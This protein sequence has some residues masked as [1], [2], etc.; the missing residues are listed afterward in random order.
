MADLNSP[1][2]PT[3]APE[4]SA[5]HSVAPERSAPAESAALG[6]PEREAVGTTQSSAACC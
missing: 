3:A 5:A 6:T 4:S 1:K 2:T